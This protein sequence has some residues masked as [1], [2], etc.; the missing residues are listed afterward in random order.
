KRFGFF[1]GFQRYRCKQCG[2]THSDFPDRPLDNLRVP[3]DQAVRVLELLC[4]GV[5]IRATERLT[6]LNRRTVLNVLEVA[7][8]KCK[9]LLDAKCKNLKVEEVQIDELY[10]FVGCLQ[11]NTT[12][13]DLL[14][15]DQ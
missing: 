7:G 2:K 4:E 5:G 15:G 9:A 6:G 8:Q 12:V 10:S 11:Q 13:D 1:K 3:L 14:R